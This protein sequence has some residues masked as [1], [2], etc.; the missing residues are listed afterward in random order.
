MD[1]NYL[2]IAGPVATNGSVQRLAIT[3]NRDT[4]LIHSVQTPD[5]TERVTYSDS[6]VIFAG[7]GDIHVHAR[8]DVTGK[9]LYKESF[10]TASLAAMNGG[11]THIADMPNNPVPPVDDH[12]WKGKNALSGS[13]FVP[14]VIYAGIGPATVPLTLQVPY[15]VFM[16]PSIGDLFFKDDD[17]LTSTLARYTGLPVSFHCEDPVILEASKNQATHESRRPAAA[18]I[19]ATDLAIALIRQYGL[20]GKL[21]HYSTGDGLKK[22]LS[23]KKEGLSVTCEVTP[24][25]LF[26]DQSML[27]PE[28][29]KWL[30]M[31]PPLRE[32]ND[33]ESL[34]YALKNGDIDYLASD[35]APHSIG[36]KEKGISGVTHLDTY[37]AFVTWLMIEKQVSA[38]TIESVCS[39]KPGQFAAP[40]LNPSRIG[41]GLG[42]IKPGYMANLTVL[43]LKKPVT[44]TRDRLR[45]QCGWS[46]FEGF[47]FPGS[48]EDTWIGGFRRSELDKGP[49]L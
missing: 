34:L 35:H 49:W 25:H 3:V 9:H 38:A 18:E 16:G 8:E 37:G 32:S 42:E 4:G 27:T 22:I 36:E 20:Q 6:C 17:T 41:A 13:S 7:F 31:N 47:T 33:K 48:V 21:C 15:K 39:V 46:P 23:A 1:S 10:R 19:K 24:T 43:N 40:F 5:G 14:L 29:H 45:T 2:S 12:S 26:F 30:Q 28:N 11:V 44:I